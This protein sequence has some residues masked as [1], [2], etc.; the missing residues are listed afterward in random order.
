M[1][2]NLWI[3]RNDSLNPANSLSYP[4]RHPTDTALLNFKNYVT[5][6]PRISGA[7]LALET[8]WHK[9]QQYYDSR[10]NRLG[11]RII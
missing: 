6:R 5:A 1:T 8:A 10:E 2:S 11:W 4:P 3:Y 9:Y 7:R